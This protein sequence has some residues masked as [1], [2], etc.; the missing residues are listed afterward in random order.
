MTLALYG[1]SRKRQFMLITAGFLAVLLSMAAVLATPAIPGSATPPANPGGH[2]E[3]PAGTVQ[4]AKFNWDKDSSSYVPEGAN[5]GGVSLGAGADDESVSWTATTLVSKI[6]VKGGPDAVV[7]T[8]QPAA[9]AGSFTNANL[10]P[11]GG[12]PNPQIPGISNIKFCGEVPDDTGSI[13]ITKDADP[14]DDGTPF[15]FTVLKD[16]AN[17]G[18]FDLQHGQSKDYPDLAPAKYDFWETNI[19]A[20]WQNVNAVC[21]GDTKSTIVWNSG[22]DKVLEITLAAGENIACTFYNEKD[23]APG[24]KTVKVLKNWSG[25]DPS[26]DDIAAFSVTIDPFES[27]PVVCDYATVMAGDCVATVGETEL[28]EVSEILPAGWTTDLLWTEGAVFEPSTCELAATASLAST[29]VEADCIHSITNTKQTQETLPVVTFYKYVCED[30]ASVPANTTDGNTPS[31]ANDVGQPDQVDQS[32]A[33]LGGEWPFGSNSIPNPPGAF[34]GCE[35]ADGWNFTLATDQNFSTNTSTTGNTSGGTVQIELTQQQLDAAEAGPNQ[36]WVKENYR[37]GEGYGF[38]AVKCHTDHLHRDNLEWID[39]SGQNFTENPVCVAFNV[40]PEDPT[41]TVQVTKTWEGGTP[42]EEQKAAFSVTITPSGDS[43]EVTCGYDTVMAGDCVATI[44]EDEGYEVIENLPAGW[45]TDTKWVDGAQFNAFCQEV[46]VDLSF[47]TVV[48]QYDC[49]HNIVNNFDG[50]QVCEDNYGAGWVENAGEGYFQ[51]PWIKKGAVHNYPSIRFEGGEVIATFE[52]KDDH[53]GFNV[54]LSLYNLPDGTKEPW[55]DQEHVDSKFQSVPEGETGPFE[56][57]IPVP[58]DVCWFQADLYFT[59]GTSETDSNGT[60]LEV[61]DANNNKWYRV[62]P[63][64]TPAP[65][66]LLNGGEGKSWFLMT[67]DD[68]NCETQEILGALSVNKVIDLNGAASGPETSFEI[69]IQQTEDA[70][71]EPVVDATPIC[72]SFPDNDGDPLQHTF[73]DL[74]LGEYTV[75]ET[76]PGS[77]WQ[78]TGSG[79]VKAVTADNVPSATITNKLKTGKVEAIKYWDKNGS[80]SWNVG[81]PGLGEWTIE[82]R[83]DSVVLDSKQTNGNGLAEFEGLA[84][85]TYEV[86]EVM[87]SAQ[88]NAGWIN[89]EPAGDAIFCQFVNVTNDGTAIAKF[90]NVQ[91]ATVTIKKVASGAGETTFGFTGPNSSTFSLGHN[92][93]SEAFE[94]YPSDEGLTFTETNVPAGWYLHGIQCEGVNERVDLGSNQVS[95]QVEGG[96]DIL[97]T[98]TNKLEKGDLKARKYHDTNG[99]GSRNSGESYLNGWTIELRQGENVVASTTTSGSGGN[100]GWARFQDIPVGDYQVCEVMSQ[101]EQDAGWVNTEPAGDDVFCHDIEV[102]KNNTSYAYFGNVK[103]GTVIIKKSAPEAGEGDS[104]AFKHGQDSFEL[105]DGEQ[106]E[107]TLLTGWNRFREFPTGNWDLAGI[108]CEGTNSDNI[109]IDLDRDRVRVKVRGGETVTCTFH[110]DLLE[111]RLVVEKATLLPTDD[112]FKF[113]LFDKNDFELDFNWLGDGETW[114][115]DNLAPGTYWVK[116]WPILT[117]GWDLYNVVCRD[118]NAGEFDVNLQQNGEWEPSIILGTIGVNL[119]PDDDVTCT[120]YNRPS[121]REVDVCKDFLDNGDVFATGP[122]DFKFKVSFPVKFLGQTINLETEKTL[123]LSEGE[124]ECVTVTGAQTRLGFVKIPYTANVT[125]TELP[126]D[127]EGWQDAAGYPTNTVAACEPVEEDIPVSLSQ[128]LETDGSMATL[129]TNDCSVTFENKV[130]A[131]REVEI[132]KVV[133]DNGDGTVHGGLFGFEID[134]RNGESAKWDDYRIEQY[135]DGEI[136]CVT[137][138]VPADAE[139]LVKETFGGAPIQGFPDSPEATAWNGNADGYPQYSVDGGSATSGLQT[140]WLAAGTEKLSVTFVNKTETNPKLIVNKLYPESCVAPEESDRPEMSLAGNGATLAFNEEA[141][142]DTWETEIEAGKTYT[143]TEQLQLG[144]ALVDYEVSGEGCFDETNEVEIAQL[145][146]V[147][148]VFNNILG[149]SLNPPLAH[150]VRIS[151]EGPGVECTV[152]FVNEPIGEIV[153]IKKR[154]VALDESWDFSISGVDGPVTVVTNQGPSGTEPPYM[155]GQVAVTLPVGSYSVTELLGANQCV[156]GATENAYDTYAD[157]A[158]NNVP[159]PNEADL[160]G[161]APLG[162]VQ[163]TKGQTTYVVFENAACGEVLSS[164]NLLIRKFIDNLA[165]DLSGTTPSN[166][167]RFRV[168]VTPEEGLPFET[169]VE[170]SDFVNG[171]AI[172][173]GIPTGTVFVEE[174]APPAGFELTGHKV[175]LGNN[176]SSDAQGSGQP[177]TFEIGL[178]E[179]HSVNFYNRELPQP[180]LQLARICIDESNG[181]AY[182]VNN[183]GPVQSMLLE[184]DNGAE[185]VITSLNGEVLLPAGATGARLVATYVGG[186]EVETGLNYLTA[187]ELDCVVET[188]TPVVETPTPTN[189]PVTETPTPVVETPTATPTDEPEDPTATPTPID[190]VEGEITPGATET[191]DALATPIPPASGS[192]FASV[193]GGGSNLNLVLFAMVMLTGGLALLSF[194]R[195]RA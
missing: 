25:A 29:V 140:N 118:N 119:E 77:S 175:D 137:D 170:G 18:N 67:S 194:S 139:I 104:F 159:D 55:E 81:E 39:L 87:T 127:Y 49:T 70:E 5:T 13:T 135:E 179:T 11:V 2:E 68:R 7:E 85:G 152:T 36:L 157:W 73:T 44:G 72:Q 166:E 23:E 64:H 143:V 22:G 40:A 32:G 121:H 153:L 96:D 91:K 93:L 190:E 43:P 89:T 184:W 115:N 183:A 10:P 86:C 53:C 174:L 126:V 41:K 30:Y 61:M 19:P 188:P 52:S 149:L 182:S 26:A 95:F 38:A 76:G 164:P 161:G 78:V 48:Q 185:T 59:N 71:G 12:G 154:S 51:Y 142:C 46:Q 24:T 192:G 56:L 191:P 110:N 116:E 156:D 27:D 42:T 97:C 112:Q 163:V 75:T 100:A 83:K 66:V 128:V 147:A 106:E 177:A 148:Q 176:G 50:Q 131:E 173:L 3:C 33:T 111:A 132:C 169:I 20:D 98:F 63:H 165:G 120:F 113:S 57:R 155:S 193:V 103:Q 187:G 125:V 79:Q 138:V 17:F 34:P 101:S 114:E 117:P 60:P 168:V 178:N 124:S 129:S 65:D 160:V 108:T 133:E 15:S 141:E 84:L 88:Q 102:T 186:L 1:K 8:V 158:V 94:F 134:T 146:V 14:S 92:Q 21:D 80:G 122:A 123:T 195:R 144:W 99:N 28:Y 171:V 9:L 145:N 181:V 162:G 35:L 69:C 47:S 62:V 167:F 58:T 4:L 172:V 107:F 90:G 180:Q 150:D 6:V 45:T 54:R 74:P 189:T 151:A 136:L 109:E 130:V 31:E 105:A 82:L 37:G 16:T